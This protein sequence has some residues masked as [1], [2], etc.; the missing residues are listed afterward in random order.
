MIRKLCWRL[1]RNSRTV[2]SFH[3]G[4]FRIRRKQYNRWM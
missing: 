3:H 2:W 4:Q 1:W